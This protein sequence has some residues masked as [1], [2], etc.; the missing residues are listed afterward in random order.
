MGQ[1]EANLRFESGKK[2]TKSHCEGRECTES[3]VRGHGR[4]ACDWQAIR[5]GSAGAHGDRRYLAFYPSHSTSLVTPS[6]REPVSHCPLQATF[7]ADG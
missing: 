2:R 6:Q 5:Y 3:P 4:L 7:R 1:N